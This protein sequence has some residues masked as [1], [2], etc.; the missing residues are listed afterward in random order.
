MTK[1]IKPSFALGYWKPLD[2]RASYWDSYQLYIRDTSLQKY[3][4]EIIG[5]YIEKASDKSIEAIHETAKR[6]GYRIDETNNNLRE[7]AN[8]LRSMDYG[9]RLQIEQQKAS[10]ILLNDIKKLLRLPDSE[11]ERTY[12]IE[13]GLKFFTNAQ[14]DP[15][16]FNDALIEFQ[17]AENI[18]NQDY[19]VLHKIGLIYLL[20]DQH[21]NVPKALEYFKR[22]AKYA[23]VESNNDIRSLAYLSNDH[24]TYISI[25]SNTHNI[26]DN[27]IKIMASESYDKAAFSAYILGDINEAIELQLKAI[28]LNAS[29]QNLFFL[30]KYQ[31]RAGLNIDGIR[32]LNNAVEILP[33]LLEITIKDLDLNSNTYVIDWIKQIV[34]TLDNKIQFL[35]VE[36]KISKSQ[37]SAEIVKEL[38]ESFSLKYPQ[39]V[40][41]WKQL[42]EKIKEY[43]SSEKIAHDNL[44]SVL[45]KTENHDFFSINSSQ[46]SELLHTIKNQL[47]NGSVEAMKNLYTNTNQLLNNDDNERRNYVNK[48][49]AKEKKEAEERDRIIKWVLGILIYLLIAV[50]ISVLAEISFGSALLFGPILLIMIL[51]MV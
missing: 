50:V 27:E 18:M 12:A 14:H 26:S 37:N 21:L 25:D 49:A 47:N 48:I 35:Q 23:S 4:A 44:T 30:G 31:M 33:E 43:N 5:K 28:K 22:A 7:I 2:E 3:N 45:N 51:A 46:K 24:E 15:D 39:R 19:F 17:K 11:R 34:E 13:L 6:L 1:I 9:I 38:K 41:L 36:W 20:V 16:L 42:S 29:A 40:N 10:N 8:E 32:S